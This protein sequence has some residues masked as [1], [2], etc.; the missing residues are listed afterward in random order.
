MVDSENYTYFGESGLQEEDFEEFIE[1]AK[2][3]DD[4]QEIINTSVIDL[5]FDTDITQSALFRK[6]YQMVSQGPGKDWNPERRVAFALQTMN[7]MGVIEWPDRPAARRSEES[8][9]SALN[10][11]NAPEHEIQTP[12]HAQQE[13]YT[14]EIF[15]YQRLTS[16]EIKDNL[17]VASAVLGVVLLAAIGITAG[18]AF[19]SPATGAGIG[20]IAVA[21]FCAVAARLGRLWHSRFTRRYRIVR[22]LVCLVL[23]FSG[24]AWFTAKDAWSTLSRISGIEM[25]IRSFGLC[26]FGLMMIMAVGA[27]I[28]LCHTDDPRTA[29]TLGWIEALSMVFA[30][31]SF[32]FIAINKP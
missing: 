31:G 14:K 7:R 16:S 2:L 22:L 23:L 29:K 18:V 11:K 26:L 10:E 8:S 3:A 30:I 25:S 6:Y 5:G 13:T 15:G 12:S 27:H 9:S 19:G 17:V 4:D 21:A 20:G 32:L 28:K 1:K 24:T